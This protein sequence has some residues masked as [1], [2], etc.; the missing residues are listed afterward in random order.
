MQRDGGKRDFHV[1][2]GAIKPRVHTIE[3]PKPS[4]ARQLPAT[5]QRV[6]RGPAT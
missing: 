3:A 5:L 1:Q 6:K 2:I 4:L